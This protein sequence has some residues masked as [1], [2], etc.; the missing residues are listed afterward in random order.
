[1]ICLFTFSNPSDVQEVIRR[2][3]ESILRSA[4]AGTNSIQTFVPKSHYYIEKHTLTSVSLR[5]LKAS[6]IVREALVEWLRENGFVSFVVEFGEL[7]LTKFDLYV[8]L[9]W[10]DRIEA[11]R[12][13]GKIRARQGNITIDCAICMEKKA[14]TALVP[15]GTSSKKSLSSSRA[16]CTPPFNRPK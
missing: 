6:E 3:R 5:S 14:A 16:T 9:K 1:M 4:K 10:H 2:I 8:E 12:E 7:S 11:A 13:C 15:C